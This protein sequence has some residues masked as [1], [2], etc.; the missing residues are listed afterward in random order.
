MRE[1][2]EAMPNYA[3]A[4]EH[5]TMDPIGHHIQAFARTQ[6]DK[7]ALT[8][9][10]GTLT[11]SEMISRANRIA[12]RLRQDGLKTGD[13]VAGL[14][15]NS[16]N[17]MCLYLGT[18]IAGGC[19]VPLSGMASGE[20]LA[21][22]VADCDSRFLFV[23][24]KNLSL[25]REI[26]DQLERVRP[27]Q[28]IGIDTRDVDSGQDLDAW[29]GDVSDQADPAEVT[30]D[31]PFNIIYS[32]GTT[33]TPKGILHDYRFR[34][35]Q[36]VRLARF[37]LDGDAINLVST[38]LYSN[39]TLVSALPTLYNG[40]TLILMGKFNAHRF[41]EL[42]E[43]HRVTHAMLVPVQYTRIMAEPDFDRFDLSS[44]KLKL[45]TSAPLRA[46]VIDEAMKRWPGNIREV[47][48]LTEGGIST[49]LD[50]AANPS[51]WDSVGV[52][53]EGAEV[54]I[55][56]DEGNEVPRGE[57]GE[58]VGRAISMMRGYY[59]RE[60]QTREMLWTSPEGLTFYRSGDMGRLDEDGFLYILDRRKDMIISGG[61]NIY[62]VDLEKVL[63]E[64]PAVADVA[65]IGI[66]SEHWGE[67][68]LGLVVRKAGASD[69]EE[70]ILAFANGKLGKT[71]RLS[72]V[73]FR[74]ELPRSTIGKVLKRELR[75]PY[76]AEPKK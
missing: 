71:Q 63:L 5:E 28:R 11:W 2:V 13:T 45:C 40:G 15:E 46:D 51:K 72:G 60:E 36:F 53:T 4:I 32:S 27:G 52:P 50:C 54:R 55:I 17:Y 7:A 10:Y 74:D 41:L 25:F 18:L 43:E 6:A 26:R 75:A 1:T 64:H 67:T 73:E 29:L 56:D 38:P 68:P 35:R 3:P 19:M 76:W 12:N 49:T 70:E 23:S 42:A 30:L 57:I 8:D 62:A 39:T 58:I 61:F 69:T 22:M 59:H 21:L 9:E 48:G 14:A 37:G 47:Y 24:E 44:F 31:D 33:G 65:V 34:Q 66:P 20:A 16:N